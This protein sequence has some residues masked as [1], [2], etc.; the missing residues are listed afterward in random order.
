[1]E[2]ISI[3][4]PNYNGK[5]LLK[6]N[7]PG[8]VK[9]VE[10]HNEN[11][12]IIVVDNGSSDGSVEFLRENYPQIRIIELKENKG[13]G[14]A[15]N[16]GVKKSKNK[17][18]ILLNND[19]M[20]EENFIEPL[21]KH[22]SDPLVFSVSAVSLGRDNRKKE[23][24]EKVKEVLYCCAGY[25]AYDKEKFLFLGGFHPI[26]SPFYCEDRDIGYRA[27]KIGWKNLIEPKS[28]V[29]H[30]G[31][32]T[33]KKLNR[34][35][36]EYIKFRNRCIFYLTCYDNPFL[37]FFSILKLIINAFFSFKW[38]TIF[39]FFFLIKNYD[40]IKQKKIFEKNVKNFICK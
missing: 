25:T 1:M 36:V 15:C 37:I 40:K 3:I 9:A 31:E 29:Y 24:P 2:P 22:F 32:R 26:Y 12:E 7:L 14:Q 30:E 20:V 28:I 16:I 8:I 18:V 34:R 13:F 17:I 33:S 10:R 5:E 19:V 39:S 21:L 38:Y 35:Y 4:I 27:K 23:I 6:K 11:D